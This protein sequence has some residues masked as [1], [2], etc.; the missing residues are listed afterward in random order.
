MGP[1]VKM[2]L[3]FMT[4]ELQTSMRFN[5]TSPCILVLQSVF[6]HETD[7]KMLNSEFSK[8]NQIAITCL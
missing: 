1:N 2:K 5:F 8:N 7:N 3:L 4:W 6:D